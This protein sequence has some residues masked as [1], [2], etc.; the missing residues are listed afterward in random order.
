MDRRNLL[1]LGGLT[2]AA[3]LCGFEHAAVAQQKIGAE[4]DRRASPRL[5][6]GGSRR[7]HGQE[8]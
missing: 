4:G 7:A 5:S 1:K 3:T 2:A 8:A 6:D